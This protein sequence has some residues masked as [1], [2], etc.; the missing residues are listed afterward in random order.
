MPWRVPGS[1]PESFWGAEK[2]LQCFTETKATLSVDIVRV[3]FNLNRFPNKAVHISGFRGEDGRIKCGV[4]GQYYVQL[5]PIYPDVQVWCAVDAPLSSC[6][7]NR[8]SDQCRLCCTHRGSCKHLVSLV[9][10]GL[11]QDKGGWTTSCGPSP[12]IWCCVRLALCW[13]GWI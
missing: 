6:P 12:E 2:R 9:L 5:W 10:G 4:H 13:Y 1:C 7:R 11:W 8:P 3:E